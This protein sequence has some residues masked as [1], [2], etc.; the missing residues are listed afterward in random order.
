MDVGKYIFLSLIY[1]KYIPLVVDEG[2]VAGLGVLEVE[3]AQ[4]VPQHCMVAAKYLN[5]DISISAL[6]GC[7]QV[8]ADGYM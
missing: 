1:V 8:P 6:H 5:M 2:S 7:G 4:A 3:L